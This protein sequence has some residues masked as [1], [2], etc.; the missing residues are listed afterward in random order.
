VNCLL[1]NPTDFHIFF[2]QARGKPNFRIF[3]EEPVM[4]RAFIIVCAGLIACAVSSPSA[5]TTVAPGQPAPGQTGPDV[6]APANSTH[7]NK[8]LIEFGWDK[9]LPAT[10]T[11]A[12]LEN[13]VFDGVI[14]RSSAGDWTFLPNALPVKA[15][16][17]DIAA[18]K[19]IK[20]KKLENS[21]YEIQSNAGQDWDWFDDA[22]WKATEANLAQIARV[23][24]QSGLRGVMFDAETYAF[25]I[26]Q[27]AVQ[28]KA[29]TF[30]FA[31][32]E[33]KLRQRGAQTIRVLEREYPGITLLTLW[34]LNNTGVDL[35]A[36]S[37]TSDPYAT[38]HAQ[39][40]N[41]G[42]GLWVAF[43]EGMLEA[44]SNG[45]KFVD[46]N[47]ESYYYLRTKDFDEARAYSKK[48]L[49]VQIR[50]DLRVKHNKQVQF[51]NAVF[52]DGIMN[53]HRSARFFGYYL[54]NDTDRQNM[55]ARNTYH[56][57]RSSEEFVWVYNEN[58][59]WWKPNSVPA[60][61][62]AALR[63]GKQELLEGKPLSND[64]ESAIQAAEI[65]FKARVD[66]GGDLLG[67]NGKVP[68][69]GTMK[70][71]CAT[72]FNATRWSCTQ[73]NGS[74]FTVTPRLD[75]VSFDPP[76]MTFEKLAKSKWEVTFKVK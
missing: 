59:D 10:V 45:V 5:K 20:S 35:A 38:L 36:A 6:A 32:Y 63:R 50:P 55:I 65:A 7:A 9:P 43:V 76:S 17:T 42:T 53:L 40:E 72:W 68:D 74:S 46:G 13:S 31:Q 69:F 73:P 26:W 49:V 71:H 24:K 16:D 23:A 3:E 60:G 25:N 58:M 57:L 66:V 39:L 21:F 1:R 19:A 15:F 70:P 34:W 47:E 64:P 22:S 67:T 62:E 44:A 8:K 51:G 56:S 41:S 29:K 4:L 52:L 33:S 12:K 28:A 27:Y 18:L 75:G 61:L 14:F 2:G 37:K 54:K 30:S 48:E 11:T